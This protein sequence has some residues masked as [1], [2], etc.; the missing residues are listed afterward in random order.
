MLF[1]SKTWVTPSFS[2]HS[3]ISS[4]VERD[5]S[6]MSTSVVAGAFAAL[7]R[8]GLTGPSTPDSFRGGQDEHPDRGRVPGLT[9]ARW[10]SAVEAT[11]KAIVRC[12][13]SRAQSSANNRSRLVAGRAGRRVRQRRGDR[14]GHLPPLPPARTGH[15]CGALMSHAESRVPHGFDHS[16]GTGH[17]DMGRVLPAEEIEQQLARGPGDARGG[18]SPPCPDGLA[19]SRPL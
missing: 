4:A 9:A 6:P 3:T 12:L 2:R 7:Q 1:R 18:F 8:T 13:P 11:S 16:G 10:C 19:A 14:L 5:C 17:L 15:G